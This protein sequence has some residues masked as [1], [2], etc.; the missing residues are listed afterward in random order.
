MHT[1]HLPEPPAVLVLQ[2]AVAAAAGRG[3]TRDA[4]GAPAQAPL[5]AISTQTK[6]LSCCSPP[7][8]PPTDLGLSRTPLL[9]CHPL[10]PSL[11]SLSQP[12]ASAAS[13]ALCNSPAEDSQTRGWSGSP[14]EVSKS[15]FHQL[16]SI[17]FACF[18]HMGTDSDFVPLS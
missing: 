4:S 3:S 10:L 18:L 6:V 17:Q 11:L 1:M 7:R 13:L 8:S 2:G 12:E 14:L 9:A 16:Q 5:L 15:Y